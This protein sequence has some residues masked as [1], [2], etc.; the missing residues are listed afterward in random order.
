[1][2]AAAWGV[3]VALAAAPLSLDGGLP[4]AVVEDVLR[5]NANELNACFHG[6]PKTAQ[7]K[8]RFGIT[9]DG[10]VGSLGFIDS[11]NLDGARVTCL[12]TLVEGLSFPAVDGGTSVELTFKPTAPFDAG[13]S[14]LE[15]PSQG[16]LALGVAESVE[17]C[18]QRNE[19]SVGDGRLALELWVAPSG[20]IVDAKVADATAG[21]KEE[22]FLSCVSAAARHWALEARASWRRAELDLIVGTTEAALRK[23]FNP[24]GPAAF[25]KVPAKPAS[26]ESQGG[27][28]KDDIMRVI[29]GNGQLIKY[30]YE[31][32]VLERGAFA[33]K[34]ALDFRIGPDGKV[35]RATVAENTTED[36]Q[37]GTCV[38]AR[39]LAWEFPKPIGGGNVDVTFPWIFMGAGQNEE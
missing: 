31:A 6:A 11:K 21:L 30:C 4:V 12:G 22:G 14:E 33:G 27:L 3:A 28:D 19:K 9:P 13:T 5:W 10:R 20:A 23:F 38:V 17:R 8:Y 16:A 18:H 39:V 2:F 15:P 1:M 24:K 7:L 37:L 29:R 32:R 34:V 36:E 35:L 26:L 25:I